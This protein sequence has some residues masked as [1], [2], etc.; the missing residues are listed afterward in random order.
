MV[1]RFEIVNLST[2][3]KAVFGR[4]KTCDYI[5]DDGLFWDGVEAVHNTYKNPRQIGSYISS[6]VINE[7]QVSIEAYCFYV[8]SKND[9]KTVL[10]SE[11]VAFVDKKI[12]LKK[13]K[14][15]R[16]VNPLNFVKI[17]IGDYSI[18]G[19][20]NKSVVF[21]S[22][23]SE[24]NEYFC[25]FTFSVFCNKPMF[26]KDVE[27]FSNISISGSSFH[28]PLVLKNT[29]FIFGTRTS[30]KIV[31]VFNEGDVEVGCKIRIE[32]NGVLT[33]PQIENT[34]TGEFIKIN[35]ILSPGEVVEINTEDN[36][37][38]GIV[39]IVDG[40]IYDYLRYWSFSNKW[41]KIPVGT[42]VLG[43]DTE[44]EGEKANMVVIVSINAA[45][46]GLGEM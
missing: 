38:K 42:T 40:K 22:T 46:F 32:A 7:R 28:F 2:N 33:K 8:L 23:N 20:P 31:A 43:Y 3:E 11:R 4:D 35:K 36:E 39:G 21:G 18:V 27:M 9:L 34:G 14:I 15:S 45:K 29:G 16:I 19:K 26:L 44:V 5:Y 10:R 13:E 30:T 17:T 24:N 41:F 12:K 37:D 25:K 6:T 1:E